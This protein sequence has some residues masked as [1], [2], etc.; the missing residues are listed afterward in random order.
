MR[1][2]SKLEKQLIQRMIELDDKAGSLNVLGNIIDS[3][4]GESHLPDHCYIELKAENDVSIQIRDEALNANAIDWIRSV[5]EDISKNLLSVVSLF[6]YLETQKL[7]YFVG[8]LNIDSLGE[9]CTDTEYKRCEFLDDDLKP[10]IYK[11]SRKKIFV[12]E[13][14]RVFVE[15]GYKT[16]EELRHETEMSSMSEQLKFTRIALGATFLGLL[17]SILVPIYVTSAI[18]IKNDRI[19]TELSPRTIELAQVA[20]SKSISPAVDGLADIQERITAIANNTHNSNKERLMND[21]IYFETVKK[22]LD[23]LIKAATKTASIIEK[24]MYESHNKKIQPTA[25]GGG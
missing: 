20:F 23:D 24:N 3:F 14:L 11:Y 13:T 19:I 22:Q 7:A 9:V 25:T 12:S 6:E 5:N 15:K 17:I 8:D 21:Q 2:F 4:Y 1:A 10:I 18:N 16:D